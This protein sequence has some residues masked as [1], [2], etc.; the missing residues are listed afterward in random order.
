MVKEEQQLFDFFLLLKGESDMLKKDKYKPDIHDWFSLT[1]AQYLT[2]PRTALQ[3][4]PNDWQIKF[5]ELLEELDNKIDW[6]PRNA[7]YW[8]LLR[9]NKTGRYIND[10][11]ANYE[12]GRRQMNFRNG[13]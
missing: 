9:D 12:R 2:I 7:T 3:S 11:L 8:C 10:P 5:V 6:R 13:K 4:M 1:Y